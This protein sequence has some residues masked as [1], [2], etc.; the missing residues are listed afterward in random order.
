MGGFFDDLPKP[1]AALFE[2]A[3]ALVTSGAEPASYCGACELAPPLVR[4]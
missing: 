1:P 2:L 3:G 4:K